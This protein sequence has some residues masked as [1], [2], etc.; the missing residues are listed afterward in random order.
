MPTEL[1]S[2]ICHRQAAISAEGVSFSY[3]GGIEAL[4]NLS[5][6]ANPGE[7]VAVLGANGSGKTTL[8]KVF[9]RLLAPRQGRVLLGEADIRSLRPV[10]MY[11][12]VG[13]VFQ[14]PAD[15]LFATSVEQDVAF[16]PR[17]LGLE[18][19]EV[20]RRVE[21]ALAAVGA[22]NL[23]SRPV[24][25]LSYG[26]QKRACLAGVLAMEPKILLLDEPTGGLDPAGEVQMIDL[27]VRLNRQRGQT[28]ILSTHEVDLLPVL[29]DRI[30]VFRS[31][32]V[33]REGKP[34]EVLADPA[35]A[36][37]A[38]LRLPLVGQLFHAL[39]GDGLAAEPLPLTIDEGR[40]QVLQWI[41]DGRRLSTVGCG[42][43]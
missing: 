30:Y 11:R 14:N 2:A 9:M 24:H 43:E 23:R 28:I 19:E 31:G 25:Q 36:A 22:L 42:P 27:L 7:M 26:Q 41:A 40:R 39:C 21:V 37:E 4:A 17:N 16:G 8:L 38:G 34:G 3:P 10:E 33:W 29:A 35:S 15:Q 13:M 1:K 32:Q 12:Q 5:F 20:R 18:P 6:R